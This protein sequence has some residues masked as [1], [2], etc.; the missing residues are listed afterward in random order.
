[1]ESPRSS[2]SSRS[3]YSENVNNNINALMGRNLAN[4]TPAA[5]NV[6]TFDGGITFS[7]NFDNGN[8]GRVE[9]VP[10]RP[11]EFK[12]WTAPD[13][14]GTMYQS[15]H[16]AW[17]YFVVTGLPMGCVLRMNL[18]NASNHNGLYKHDM[19]SVLSLALPFL[20]CKSSIF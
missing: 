4:E 13:N 18:V 11:Y 19:V 5:H 10:N 12:I 3:D 15:R 6:F 7:S 9:R 14:M 16:C 17:F 2:K 8:L 20:H 1:M